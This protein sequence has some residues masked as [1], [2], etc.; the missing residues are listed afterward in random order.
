MHEMTP[1]TGVA[2][3]LLIYSVKRLVEESRPCL[4][5]HV[6]VGQD[7]PRLSFPTPSGAVVVEKRASNP[8]GIWT[9]SGPGIG[10]QTLPAVAA[11][12]AT[13]ALG[14]D[15]PVVAAA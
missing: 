13:V 8:E 9:V 4:Q 10:I 12:L 1:D 7:R 15:A 3:L 11:R 2:D 5:G 6:I 14:A